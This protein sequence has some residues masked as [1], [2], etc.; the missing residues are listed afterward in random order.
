L[1]QLSGTG[2]GTYWDVYGNQVYV[3]E[4]LVLDADESQVV[5]LQT[6]YEYNATHINVGDRDYITYTPWTVVLTPSCY[7]YKVSTRCYAAS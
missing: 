6:V 3:R 4:P 2:R 1:L 7:Y 5:L